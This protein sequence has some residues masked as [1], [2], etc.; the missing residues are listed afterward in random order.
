MVLMLRFCLILCLSV[1]VAVALAS[2]IRVEASDDRAYSAFSE[3]SPRQFD[4]WIGAWDVRMLA[5]DDAGALEE[6]GTAEAA[7]HSIL[8]GAGI[9]EL[10]A[11]RSSTSFGL[12]YFDSTHKVWRSWLS[13]QHSGQTTMEQRVGAFGHG[14]GEFRNR[15]DAASGANPSDAYLYSDITP[16]SLR[17]EH[18]QSDDDRRSWRRISALEYTRSQVEPRPLDRRTLPTAGTGDGCPDRRFSDFKFMVGSWSSESARFEARSILNGCAVVGFLEDEVGA[19][20]LIFV[21]FDVREERWMSLI[22]S[23]EPGSHPTLYSG[24]SNWGDLKASDERVG[25]IRWAILHAGP[26]NLGDAGDKFYY[27]LNGRKIEFVR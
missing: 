23:D 27:Q 4:F 26:G 18:H 7:V 12:H 14:R 10:R 22:F 13:V 16:F 3:P 1:S 20:Q 24:A 6:T 8:G 2:D 19:D 11:S 5:G 9:L 25:S 21:T 17:L 15:S